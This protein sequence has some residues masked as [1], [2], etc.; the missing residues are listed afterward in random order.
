[1]ILDLAIIDSKYALGTSE[2]SMLTE[3]E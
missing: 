1:M 3:F 2:Y